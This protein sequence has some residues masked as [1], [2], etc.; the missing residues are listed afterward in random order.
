MSELVGLSR[1]SGTTVVSAGQV[2][3]STSSGIALDPTTKILT[4]DPAVAGDGLTLTAGVLAID[5]TIA[6]DGLAHDAGVLAVDPG[7]GLDIDAG[8][9]RLAPTVAGANLTYLNGVL[10]ASGGGGGSNESSHTDGEYNIG[11]GQTTLAG[12]DRVAY[13]F[14]GDSLAATE[15]VARLVATHVT[16][17]KWTVGDATPEDDP[18]PT[19]KLGFEKGAGN[20]AP[21]VLQ[22]PNETVA[23][24]FGDIATGTWAF[25]PAS[26]GGMNFLK[27]DGTK[28]DVR[29]LLE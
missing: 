3:V 15:P 22:V 13:A 23:V 4:L 5:P 6:G 1:P 18:V 9:V 28:W 2:G 21:L 20:S 14:G 16:D 25:G 26:G 27:Y 7:N 24:I 8:K 10:S 29:M 11:K 12:V 17:Q 19:L